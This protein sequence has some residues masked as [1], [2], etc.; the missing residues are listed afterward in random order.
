MKGFQK[1]VVLGALLISAGT[2]VPSSSA[3]W[4]WRNPSPLGASLRSVAFGEGTYVAVGDRGAILVSQD[5]TNW[6][7]RSI[8][9]PFAFSGVAYGSGVF[10][11]VGDGIWVSGEGN[12]W[13]QISSSPVMLR[14]VVYAEAGFTA[15][16]DLGTI[17]ASD[18]GFGWSY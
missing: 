6:T 2:V 10:I 7:S 11:A 9:T 18:Y 5:A 17:F 1:I 4:Q 8:T 14:D 15:V 12:N 16:G 13:F 3:T